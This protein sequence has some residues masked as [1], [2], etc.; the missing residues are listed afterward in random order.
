MEPLKNLISPDLVGWIATHLA[1]HQRGF[2]R[3]AFV[4]AIL[5]ALPGLELKERA[6]LIADHLH[7]ELPADLPARFKVIR[8]MLHPEEDA[9]MDRQS[10]DQGLRG[11][12]MMP[13]CAVVGQHGSREFEAALDL[14]KEMTKRFS[15]E[16]DVRYFLLADQDRALDVMR[17]WVAD[18]NRHVRRLVSEGTRPRLPWAMRLPA[19]VADPAPI[20]PLLLA[21][22]DDEEEYVRRSVANSLNDIAKDHPDRIAALAVEWLQG[23]GPSRVRLLKHACRSLIKDGHPVVMRAFG[24]KPPEVELVSLELAPRKLRLGQTLDVTARLRSTGTAPQ[25]IMID[26]VL[27]LCRANGSLSKKV[28]KWKTATLAP[29]ETLSL[30]RSH[31]IVPITTRRYYSGTHAISLRINGVDS[32]YAEFLL[33]V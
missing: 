27:H 22:R 9:S 31:A 21:L 33:Q 20:L 8:D 17:G 3:D 25:A 32:G 10:D 30:G 23:A 12:A 29:G 18:P 15:S 5:T 26:Y 1:R 4:T 11:W 14:L 16:F 24:L 13:L 6:Q 2:D 7:A 19:L 28:F